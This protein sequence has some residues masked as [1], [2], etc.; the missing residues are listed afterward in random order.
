MQKE[1]KPN[2]MSRPGQ[3][4][5]KAAKEKKQALAHRHLYLEPKPSHTSLVFLNS[6]LAILLR[7]IVGAGEEH[8][9]VAGLFLFLAD[10]AWLSI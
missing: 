9:V 4:L 1:N 8:A 5:T 10:T 3:W 6:A 2:V 7:G